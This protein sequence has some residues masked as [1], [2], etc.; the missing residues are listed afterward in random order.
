MSSVAAAYPQCNVAPPQ[1]GLFSL[2]QSRKL[3]WNQQLI[4]QQLLNCY[5]TAMTFSHYQCNSNEWSKAGRFGFSL[6]DPKDQPSISS[7]MHALWNNGDSLLISPSFWQVQIRSN[8]TLP[9]V[10]QC[11]SEQKLSRCVFAGYELLS[12]EMAI[13]IHRKFQALVLFNVLYFARTFQCIVQYHVPSK[14]ND[15]LEEF[16]LSINNASVSEA[17]WE[18]SWLT[19]TLPVILVPTALKITYKYMH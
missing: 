14:L 9:R 13:K 7:E 17:G 11:G 16:M 19:G 1:S 5:Q 18:N 10:N 3:N 4:S 15:V 6:P 8:S 12:N 2:I